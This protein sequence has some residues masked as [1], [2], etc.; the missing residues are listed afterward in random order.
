[1]DMLMDMKSLNR[2]SLKTCCKFDLRG[3][4][5]GKDRDA[6]RRNAK[7]SERQVWRRDIRNYS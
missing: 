5:K 7:R 3:N 6:N 1:M 2:T 4:G